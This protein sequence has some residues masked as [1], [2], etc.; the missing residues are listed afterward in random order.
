MCR[1]WVP[2]RSINSAPVASVADGKPPGDTS[3]DRKVGDR[4]V[5]VERLVVKGVPPTLRRMRSPPLGRGGGSAAPDAG[6]TAALAGG[7]GGDPPRQPS[8]PP[9]WPP[10]ASMPAAGRG[11]ARGRGRGPAAGDRRA[12][13]A[14]DDA[15]EK[16]WG[17]GDR[18]GREGGKKQRRGETGG[19][20]L[21][22]VRP[23]RRRPARQCGPRAHHEGWDGPSV[24]PRT[25]RCILPGHPLPP[26]HGGRKGGCRVWSG[27]A[28][29]CCVVACA[30]QGVW[31]GQPGGVG[32]RFSTALMT[33]PIWRYLGSNRYGTF[34][35]DDVAQRRVRRRRWRRPSPEHSAVDSDC[36]AGVAELARLVVS[37]AI[38]C[39]R[40]N[41]SFP[42]VL[43]LLGHRPCVP[44]ARHYLHCFLAEPSLREKLYANS[45]L[46]V[47]CI[48]ITRTAQSGTVP[49][50]G[51]HIA[52]C[53]LRCLLSSYPRQYPRGS[54]SNATAGGVAPSSGGV[55]SRRCRTPD[56]SDI[57][58]GR[59]NLARLDLIRLDVVRRVRPTSS[60][61]YPLVSSVLA[62]FPAMG[63]LERTR[64]ASPRHERV[65]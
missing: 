15:D 24:H 38:R 16:S 56:S 14:E 13:P 5:R 9:S 53:G 43:A 8:S 31:R 42:A 26:P 45:K 4:A 11:G 29:S 57:R 60:L 7:A 50:T 39:T 19:G 59:A 27:R 30:V 25:A 49:L 40:Q 65:R 63:S 52:G 6:A 44:H 41:R 46:A 18:A 62:L 23:R 58:K 36:C 37:P 64:T 47:R 10:A 21:R 61:P 17:E 12:T 1:K 20:G 33:T 55:G 2:S 34:T 51:P 22:G 54:K 28:A 48:P 35:N 32:F 3:A